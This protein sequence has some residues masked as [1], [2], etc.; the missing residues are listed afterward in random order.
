MTSKSLAKQSRPL[1]L[2]APE[3]MEAWKQ[4]R[5]SAQEMLSQ[6]NLTSLAELFQGSLIPWKDVPSCTAAVAKAKV[7]L[8]SSV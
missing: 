8:E 3:T 1:H 2:T 7:S 4:T 5:E 6:N